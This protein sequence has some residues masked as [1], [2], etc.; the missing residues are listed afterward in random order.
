MRTH[1]KLAALL[2]AATLTTA[3]APAVAPAHG[4]GGWHGN[5]GWHGHH[6]GKSGFRVSAQVLLV[7]ATQSN[8]FEIAAGQLAQQRGGDAVRALGAMLVEDHTALQQ[9]VD[10]AAA[11][12][13]VTL[14]TE[15]SR[16]AQ[17]WLD[18]LGTLSGDDFDEAWVQTQIGAH[19]KALKLL[20]AGATRGE[21]RELRTVAQGALPVVTRHLGDL[22]DLADAQS[23]DDEVFGHDHDDDRGD[24]GGRHH[25][26][27]HRGR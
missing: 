27:H 1:G 13:G 5:G 26:R 7:G 6:H 11:A 18:K 4:G 20:L 10:A 15:L 14:P 22:Y 25:G 17:R 21:T 3:A 19:E 12:A 2:A 8:R 23:G 24:R 16:G 9:Q